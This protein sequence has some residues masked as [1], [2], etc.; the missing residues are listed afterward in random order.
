MCE[1]SV[2][3]LAKTHQILTAN[4]FIEMSSSNVQGLSVSLWV[5]AEPFTYGALPVAPHPRLSFHVS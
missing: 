4:S 2:F 3:P 1:Y 5:K